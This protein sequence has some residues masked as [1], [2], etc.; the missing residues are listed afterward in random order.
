MISPSGVTPSSAGLLLRGDDH[1]GAAVGD[2]A[3]VAGGDVAGLVERRAEAAEALGGGVA[4]DALVLLDHDRVAPPLR[5]L[6]RDDLVVEQ[7]VL[8]GRRGPLVALGRQLV[9]RG[10]LEA[11]RRGVLLGA[12]AHRDLVEGAEQAVVHH[13]VDDLLVA[14]AVAGTGAREQVGR[15]GHRL[16]AA[17]HHDVGVARLHELVGQVDR[18]E[19][20]QAHLV[21]GRRRDRHGDAGVDRG[22]AGGDLAGAG[23]EHLAHEHVVDLVGRE[24]G[25]LEGGL[26]REPAEVRGVERGEGARQLADRRASASEDHGT[27]HVPSPKGDDVVVDRLPGG[28]ASSPQRPVLQTSVRGGV[29]GGAGARSG[30]WWSCRRARRASD[31][32]RGAPVRAPRRA[33]PGR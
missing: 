21:H 33:R 25:P 28:S 23:L 18:V 10:P 3:G 24:A 32:R 8:G 1:R 30:W 20:G 2:L 5:H 29:G 15:L 13:R 4:A 14:E 27:G 31:R 26:D 9:L 7:A 19:A 11:G 22:L 12:G 6:D 17:G 16:H